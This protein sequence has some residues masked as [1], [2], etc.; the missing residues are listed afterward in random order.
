MDSFEGRLQTRENELQLA[1]HS[2]NDV[3]GKLKSTSQERNILA[4]QL[5]EVTKSH[6]QEKERADK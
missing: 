4:A 5:Q 6:Q 3:V 1:Q 2:Y